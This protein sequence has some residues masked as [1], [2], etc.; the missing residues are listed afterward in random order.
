MYKVLITGA[1]GFVGTNLSKYLSANKDYHL[2]ALDI[3]KMTIS[4][5]NREYRWM[6]IHKI[7]FDT[8]DTV[9][10]LAGKAHDTN[11][12]SDVNEYFEINVGLT[13]QVFCQFIK[14][15][16]KKFIYISSVKAVADSVI[17][18][19][20]TEEDFPHPQ[21]PY[22]Q[23]KLKAEKY[24]LSQVLPEGKSL[25]ILRPA[26]I[27][28]PGNKGNLNL[29]FN[30][31]KKGIPYPLGAFSN[32]RSFT[33]IGNLN[34]VMKE[35]IEREMKSGIYQVADKEMLSTNDVIE[36]I[37]EAIRKKPKIW[38]IPV[39]LI[40]GIAMMGNILSLPLNSEKLKKLTENYLVSNKKLVDALGVE[41][42]IAAR[43]G[44]KFTLRS[45]STNH[46]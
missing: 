1:H 18:G 33:S 2:L 22:G 29:L 16:A 40:K 30:L 17:D 15:K 39:P 13:K 8:I 21:T 41:L 28:G 6:E 46:Y 19:M 35:F 31:I 45:L 34:F 43:E 42:P 27:H 38:N 25:F 23:S 36:L 5:Y 11:N 24:L 12:V 9:I 4:S 20:L 7:D 37:G 32:M 14:S 10:H 44:L 26:M 3:N